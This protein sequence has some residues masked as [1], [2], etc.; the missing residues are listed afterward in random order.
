M[1]MVTM[2]TGME[3]MT[4]DNGSDLTEGKKLDLVKH[5]FISLVLHGERV[6]LHLLYARYHF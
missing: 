6:P 5:S 1:T 3:G 4:C 2:V